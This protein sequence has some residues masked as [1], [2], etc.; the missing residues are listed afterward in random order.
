MK[1][2][3][4][5]KHDVIVSVLDEPDPNETVKEKGKDQRRF[6]DGPGK[7]GC[8][9]QEVEAVFAAVKVDAEQVA[10]PRE[11]EN[12]DGCKDSAVV[13]ARCLIIESGFFVR[14]G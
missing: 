7:V 12:D 4:N 1:R 10:T 11:E 5:K 6:N 3:R 14:G 9:R 13:S 8:G 2:Y